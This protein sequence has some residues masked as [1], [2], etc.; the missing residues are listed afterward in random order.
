MQLLV[1]IGVVIWYPYCSGPCL[2]VLP[3]FFCQKGALG[4]FWL[5]QVRLSVLFSRESY[6][7]DA[8]CSLTASGPL[9]PT[10][11]YI[12]IGTKEFAWYCLVLFGIMG[13]G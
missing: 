13:L 7:M 11:Y 10:R 12:L 9:G 8:V 4:H 5:G 1:A 6:I 3:P 2:R